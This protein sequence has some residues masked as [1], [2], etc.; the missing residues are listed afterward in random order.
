MVRTKVTYYKLLIPECQADIQA[1]M[2]AAEEHHVTRIMASLPPEHESSDKEVLEQ[3]VV[4]AP[5]GVEERR[6]RRSRRQTRRRHR[7]GAS[8]IRHGGPVGGVRARPSRGGGGVADH[9][10]IHP[11]QG[12]G[13]VKPPLHPRGGHEA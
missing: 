5:E 3:E 12:G 11:V 1:K 9:P 10:R 8:Q 7:R 4:E 6:S 13:G 2:H